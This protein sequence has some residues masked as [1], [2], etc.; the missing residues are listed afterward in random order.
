MVFFAHDVNPH[1][2]TRNICTTSERVAI[3]GMRFSDMYFFFVL[4]ALTHSTT[5]ARGPE[6][7]GK[8]MSQTHATGWATDTPP[9]PKNRN[10]RENNGA[11]PR[12]T[13]SHQIGGYGA[14]KADT[15]HA[16]VGG[17]SLPVPFSGG[18]AHLTRC[19]FSGGITHQAPAIENCASIVGGVFGGIQ[20]SGRGC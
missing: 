3:R 11:G 13:D 5:I 16:L 4:T 10:I 17:R 2:S 20:F 7:S 12:P 14:T 8:H 18:T 15:G 6:V 9:H 1:V 19:H